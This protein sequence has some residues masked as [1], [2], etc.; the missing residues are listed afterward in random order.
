MIKES[1]EHGDD[2]LY[3]IEEFFKVYRGSQLGQEV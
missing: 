2:G 3:L 1:F